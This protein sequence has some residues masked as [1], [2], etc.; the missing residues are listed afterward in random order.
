MR[1]VRARTQDGGLVGALPAHGRREL[2]LRE[3]AGQREV[4]RVALAAEAERVARAHVAAREGER[5]VAV[6]KSPANREPRVRGVVGP[7]EV[8][9]HVGRRARL[10]PRVAVEALHRLTHAVD[11]RRAAGGGA[12]GGRCLGRKGGAEAGVARRVRCG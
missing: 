11:G 1:R 10:F 12:E 5:A 4:G 6:D 7:D 9:A 8:R 3:L 2:R